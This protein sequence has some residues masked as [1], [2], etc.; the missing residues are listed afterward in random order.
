MIPHHPDGPNGCA[1]L[2]KIVGVA[3]LL[4]LALLAV[5]PTLVQA[6]HR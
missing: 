3:L 5:H 1:E 2:A 6:V 4:W